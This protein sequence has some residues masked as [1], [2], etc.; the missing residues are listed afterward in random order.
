MGKYLWSYR[1]VQFPMTLK[2]I[3]M[4]QDLSNATRR[5]SVRHFTRFQPAVCESRGPSAIAELLVLNRQT[6]GEVIGK[7]VA[8][9]VRPIRRA[10]LSLKMHNTLDK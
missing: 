2:V 8:C 3:R 1:F 6:F 10:L 5:T 9:V 4:L 7:I